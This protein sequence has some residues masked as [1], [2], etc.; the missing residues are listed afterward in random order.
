MKKFRPEFFFEFFSSK[1]QEFEEIFG[2]GVN[3][4]TESPLACPTR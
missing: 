4:S 3:L 1:Y 2:E